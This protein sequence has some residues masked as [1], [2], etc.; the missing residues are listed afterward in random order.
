M[1]LETNPFLLAVTVIVTMLHMV[2]DV[3]AFKNDIAFW[4]EQ[5]D[6][7]GLSVRTIFVNCFCS[8]RLLCPVSASDSTQWPVH[9]FPPRVTNIFFSKF[10]DPSHF[11]CILGP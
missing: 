2:F 4:K 8:V 10:T 11:Q 5:K 6:M 1:L 7:T 3:L 9:I